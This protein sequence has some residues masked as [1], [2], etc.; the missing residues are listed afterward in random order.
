VR[1]QSPLRFPLHSPEDLFSSESSTSSS[2]DNNEMLV[3]KDTDNEIRL[4]FWLNATT[5][6]HKAP[7]WRLMGDAAT[8]LLWHSVASDLSL[9]ISR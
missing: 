9:L 5:S 1:V 4:L 6:C 8:A 7:A 2:G 3:G